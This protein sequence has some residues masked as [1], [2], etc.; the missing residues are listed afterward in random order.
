M[1]FT[2]IRIYNNPDAHLYYDRIVEL[3]VTDGALSEEVARKRIEEVLFIYMDGENVAGI[4]T[5]VNLYVKQLK[6]NFIFYSCYTGLKYRKEKISINIWNDT[7]DYFNINQEYKG[8]KVSGLYIIYASEIYSSIR[9]LYILKHIRDLMLIGFNDKDQQIRVS[10]F[11][12]AE[13]IP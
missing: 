2:S 12:N 11:D 8:L 9:R 4:C 13:F 1:N 6:N 10:Y 5:G 3:W 7:F